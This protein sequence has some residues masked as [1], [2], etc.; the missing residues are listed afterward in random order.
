MNSMT[1]STPLAIM[2]APNGARKGHADHPNLPVTIDEIARDGGACR[3]TGVQAIHMQVR[4]DGGHHS[5]DASRYIAATDAV[6]RLAGRHLI[7]Q[8]PTEAVRQ[9]TPPQ[10]IA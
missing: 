7:V 8:M 1:G 5:I 6:R 9:F 3:S 4:D 2:M 10:Q